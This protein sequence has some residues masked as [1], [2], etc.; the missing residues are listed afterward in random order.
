[1]YK[2][3]QGKDAFVY[4]MLYIENNESLIVGYSNGNLVSFNIQNF[5][6]EINWDEKIGLKKPISKIT[7]NQISNTI[8]ALEVNEDISINFIKEINPTNGR[9]LKSSV[10]KNCLVI[11]MKIFEMKHILTRE[12]EIK[13]IQN[14]INNKEKEI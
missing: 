8:Y 4:N 6:F 2:D 10:I 1:M 7:Y 14:I 12:E 3:E 11:N 9:I 5:S 13:V